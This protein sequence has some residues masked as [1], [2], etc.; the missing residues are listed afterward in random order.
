MLFPIQRRFNGV[1]FAVLLQIDSTLRENQNFQ[2]KLA[3]QRG[4]CLLPNKKNVFVRPNGPRKLLGQKILNAFQTGAVWWRTD[5]G[6][7]LA[8]RL[9]IL[10][11][12]QA[13]AWLFFHSANSEP[14]CGA[15]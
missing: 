1:H 12:I 2:L 4:E 14:Y 6:V 5:T 7:A 13:K 11:G 9:L 10:A 15:V 8:E 3:A